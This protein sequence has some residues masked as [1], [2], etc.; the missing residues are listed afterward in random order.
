MSV[1]AVVAAAAILALAPSSEPQAQTKGPVAP[2]DAC[3]LLSKGEV[4]ALMGELA[5][6]GVGERAA[7]LATCSYGD[8]EA[9]KIAGR[10]ASQILVLAVLTGQEGAYAAGPV[11]QARDSFETARRNAASSQAV[12]GLGDAAYWD[13]TFKTLGVHRGRYFVSAEVK[14]G[15]DAAKKVLAKALARLP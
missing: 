14:A 1:V 7:N 4:E 3:S 11:A 13:E 8:P 2:V 12:A 5:L 9:P 10:P 15:L 6:A